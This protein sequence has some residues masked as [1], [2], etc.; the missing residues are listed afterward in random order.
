ML[1]VAWKRLICGPP[2][3]FQISYDVQSRRHGRLVTPKFPHLLNANQVMAQFPV[4]H[5]VGRLASK[6]VQPT[7]HLGKR[8]T[9][10]GFRFRAMFCKRGHK[11]YWE[12]R[13]GSMPAFCNNSDRVFALTCFIIANSTRPAASAS[14]WAWWW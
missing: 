4:A 11:F 10:D 9:Q 5:A 14:A 2:F 3:L 12:K 7:M 6:L 13:F 8:L 1:F